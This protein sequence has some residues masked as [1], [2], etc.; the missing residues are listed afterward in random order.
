MSNEVLARS[1]DGTRIAAL[2][3]SPCSSAMSLGCT[4][5]PHFKECGGLCVDAPI[6]DCLDLCCGSPS[7]CSRVC[8]NQPSEIYVDQLRE[9]DGFDFGNV[10]RAQEVA[11]RIDDDIV[12]LVYH[13][14]R[15]VGTLS[16]SAFALRLSDL[17]NYRTA[18]L[19]FK[20]RAE[21][22]ESYRIPSD[23]RLILS[24]VNQDHR[25][26]PWWTLGRRRL[27]II[28]EM[29][30]LGV[31]LVTTPNFSV[32]L[33]QPRTDDLHAMKRILVVFS[34]FAEAG[35]PCALHPNGRTERDFERWSVEI[36][37]RSEIQ[38]LSYEF[39]TG[40]ARY[41]RREWHLARLA[42]LAAATDRSLDIVVRGDPRVVPF[43]RKHFRNVIY[44]ETSAFVRTTKRRRAERVGNRRVKWVADMTLPG[45][46]L[47]DL[48]AH[49]LEE[50]N[51]VLRAI[52]GFMRRPQ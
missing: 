16:N 14:S 51:A 17:V 45:T 5:C 22:C 12:P 39:T 20:T 8:R 10:A 37:R 9:I 32:I 52:P 2:T 33:D 38:T 19:K 35:L 30:N 18:R 42:E 23:S 34:E 3:H 7:K 36:S 27:P 41:T 43:L 11:H 44:I 6:F 15:R 49:N 47:D 13:G 25:I 4:T 28:A 40:T 26:E 46:S 1:S 48:F 29:V 50:R 24:G 21:L 31:S